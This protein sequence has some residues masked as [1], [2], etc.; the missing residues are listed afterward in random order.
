MYLQYGK[1]ISFA[2]TVRPPRWSWVAAAAP[3]SSARLLSAGSGRPAA[4]QPD[5]R[6]DEQPAISSSSSITTSIAPA[7]GP[8]HDSTAPNPDDL[9]RGPS[10]LEPGFLERPIR[11]VLDRKS[12]V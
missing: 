1:G 8:V 2:E 11:E 4:D 6:D 10:F 7:A 3:R 9:K 12:V 5:G